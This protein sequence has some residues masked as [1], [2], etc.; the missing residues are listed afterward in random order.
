MSLVV[1]GSEES[2]ERGKIGLV[3]IILRN[4]FIKVNFEHNQLGK[5]H[6][7]SAII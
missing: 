2:E 4:R 7:A 5:T 3:V 6:F 1:R